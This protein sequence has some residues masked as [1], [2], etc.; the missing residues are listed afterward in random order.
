MGHAASLDEGGSLR[1][2]LWWHDDKQIIRKYERYRPDNMSTR[3]A[4]YNLTW[5]AGAF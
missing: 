5:R 4:N 2:A 1:S 3:D